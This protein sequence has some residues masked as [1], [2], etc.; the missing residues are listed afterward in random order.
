[1]KKEDSIASQFNAVYV[2]N[3]TPKIA[4]NVINDSDLDKYNINPFDFNT[5]IEHKSNWEESYVKTFLRGDLQLLKFKPYKNLSTALR[6]VDIYTG[7]LS[8]SLK[9]TDNLD[10]SSNQLI[11]MCFLLKFLESISTIE[12]GK[13]FK[14]RYFIEF[15]NK[16]LWDEHRWRLRYNKEM[17]KFTVSSGAQSPSHGVVHKQIYNLLRELNK[18]LPSL[19]AEDLMYRVFRI[20]QS[21]SLDDGL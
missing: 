4:D 5:P 8:H 21:I 19:R 16:L 20:A 15:S 11:S 18:A 7:Y 1:M 2:P 14:A 3:R 9:L 17:Y 13:E 12:I 10:D 6:A